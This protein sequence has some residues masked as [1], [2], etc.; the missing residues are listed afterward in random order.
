MEA[1]VYDP[2]QGVLSLY[3]AQRQPEVRPYA[4]SFVLFVTS[5]HHPHILS[6]T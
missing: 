5:S 2:E 1:A 3:R 4:L 6:L